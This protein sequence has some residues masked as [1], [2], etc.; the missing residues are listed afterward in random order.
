MIVKCLY[1]TISNLSDDYLQAG[2]TKESV[3]DI[4]L[5]SEYTI[6][7]ISLW[8]GITL[9]LVFDETNMPNWYPANLFCITDKSIPPNWFFSFEYENINDAVHSILG[10]KELIDIESHFN[11]LIDR[12]KSALEIFYKRKHQIDHQC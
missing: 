11:D 5:E 9:Y 12:K 3:F 4:K 1:K 10:Y 8:K 6:Y 2:Y 7:G